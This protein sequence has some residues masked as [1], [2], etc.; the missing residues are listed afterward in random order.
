M[1]RVVVTGIGIVS[2]I[3]N[4]QDEVLDSLKNGRSGISFCEDYQERGFRSHVHGDVKN[5]DIADHVDKKL[6]PASW[7]MALL[8][9][10][11][12]WNRPSKMPD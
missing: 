1:R 3:G 2:S 8:T 6:M 5:L 9:T 7:V 11:L 12:P 10:I 4:N